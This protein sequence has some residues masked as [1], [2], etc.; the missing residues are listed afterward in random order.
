[1]IWLFNVLTIH[2]E[3][4]HF[5]NAQFTMQ[6]SVYVFICDTLTI[7]HYLNN[8]NINNLMLEHVASLLMST[9][10]LLCLVKAESYNPA[11]CVSLKST[12][13]GEL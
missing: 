1:M 7:K 10:F 8:G 5:P 9:S 2:C 4:L 6:S 11:K 12:L 13:Y 3:I